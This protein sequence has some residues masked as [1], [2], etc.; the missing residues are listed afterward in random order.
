MEQPKQETLGVGEGM[1]TSPV[2][3]KKYWVY[4]LLIL[5]TPSIL[6]GLAELVYSLSVIELV[7]I[8]VAI[9]GFGLGY[10]FLL[11]EQTRIVVQGIII[12]FVLCPLILYV[13]LS[14]VAPD[15]VGRFFPVGFL[16]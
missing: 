2:G 5:A 3:Y 8:C 16:G 9:V 13:A 4:I 12:V 1:Q 6:L 7:L 10:R 14:I 15:L 11:T